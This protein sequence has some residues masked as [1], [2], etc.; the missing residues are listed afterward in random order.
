VTLPNGEKVPA[1][2]TAAERKVI[3]QR[4][5]FLNGYPTRAEVETKIAPAVLQAVD[6]KVDALVNYLLKNF[7]LVPR[8][9]AGAQLLAQIRPPEPAPQFTRWQRILSRLSWRSGKK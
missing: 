5:A 3:Q 4:I 9:E 2:K 8:T 1:P 7:D 6:V